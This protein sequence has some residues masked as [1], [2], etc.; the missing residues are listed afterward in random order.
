MLEKKAGEP[1]VIS[2]TKCVCLFIDT[3]VVTEG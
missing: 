2:I 1:G 3:K